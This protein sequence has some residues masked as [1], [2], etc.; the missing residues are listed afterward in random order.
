[1]VYTLKIS[2][3]IILLILAMIPLALVENII[4]TVNSACRC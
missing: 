2:N 1:M 4:T 3:P